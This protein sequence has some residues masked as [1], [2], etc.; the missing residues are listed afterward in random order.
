LK[1]V[2]DTALDIG[3]P[4]GNQLLAFADALFGPDAGALAKARAAL[5]ESLG[6]AAV[7]AASII[8]A[9]FT[10]NDRVAN[11]TGIPAEPRMFNG[12]EDIREMLGLREFKSARN[13]YRHLPADTP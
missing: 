13:T 8:A 9:S 12:A 6:P 5:Q 10:K 4:G 3:F 1:A 2:I 7:T 11:C